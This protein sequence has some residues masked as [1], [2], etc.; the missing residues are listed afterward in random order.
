[1]R[2]DHLNR[3]LVL[4][5]FILHNLRQAVVASARVLTIVIE[6][7]KNYLLPCL[8]NF[9]VEVTE[10]FEVIAIK[11]LDDLWILVTFEVFV[12]EREFRGVGG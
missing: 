9:Y 6:D 4:D 1:M 8:E 7:K 2:L 5:G 11:V 10:R 12:G 3:W